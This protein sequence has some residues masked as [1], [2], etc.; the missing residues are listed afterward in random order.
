[1]AFSQAEAQRYA[2]HFA[3]P[4]VGEQGQEKLR[5]ASVLVVGTGGLGSPVALYLAAA[6]VGRLT[7][8]DGDAVDISNLQRQILYSTAEVSRPKAAQAAERVRALNPEIR[9]DAVAE[10]VEAGNARSLVREHDLVVDGTDNFETRYLVN[11]ACVLEH[12]P[13]VFGAVYRFDAQLSVFGWRGGPC[14]RCV[15]PE[16]PAPE[17]MPGCAEAGVLGVLPG[18]VG[19]LMA[20][21]AL[22][23]LLGV[24]EPLSGQLLVYEALGAGF[25]KVR[26]ARRADCAVCGDHPSIRAIRDRSVP[27]QA[28]KVIEATELRQIMTQPPGSYLLLDVRSSE[29]FRASRLPGSVNLPLERLEAESSRLPRGLPWVIVCQSGQRSA[30]AVTLLKSVGITEVRHVGGGLNAVRKTGRGA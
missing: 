27:E 1:M 8:V 13:L 30:R 17:A 26:V 21:E 15:Y 22:K 12:K 16:A 11:D 14:Y 29:E 3:L 4:E 25:Q 10:R 6:G 23:L 2:R 20:T 28:G 24:G 7:L 9:V 5:S 18:T 19:T